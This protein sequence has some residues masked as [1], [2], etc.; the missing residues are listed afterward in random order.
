MMFDVPISSLLHVCVWLWWWYMFLIYKSKCCCR[1]WY[2]C[3]TERSFGFSLGKKICTW[4][5]FRQ[6]L[7]W[8]NVLL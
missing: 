4:I 1:C 7:L 3:I 2:G 8:S 6:R 5:C